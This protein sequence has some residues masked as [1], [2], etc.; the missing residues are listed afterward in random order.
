[1]A[2]KGDLFNVLFLALWAKCK[3]VQGVQTAVLLHGPPVVKDMV[4][5]FKS[6]GLVGWGYDR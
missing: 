4:S 3:W 5:Y 1:M 2:I 6:R